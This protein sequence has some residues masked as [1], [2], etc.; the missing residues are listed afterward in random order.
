MAAIVTKEGW[1]TLDMIYTSGAQRWTFHESKPDYV[2]ECFDA[3]EGK[4][5]P[6]T[7]KR[8]MY[9]DADDATVTYD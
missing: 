4:H 1:I 5:K 8:I 6:G 3:A 9:F 7:M 2:E